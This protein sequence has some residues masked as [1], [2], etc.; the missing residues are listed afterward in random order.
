[1]ECGGI[2]RRLRLS[3][4]NLL[5]LSAGRNAGIWARVCRLGCD[6]D[7]VLQGTVQLLV[8]W[9]AGLRAAFECWEFA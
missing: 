8:Y 7:P 4:H 9:L 1:M 2:S 6:T 3:L 5:V